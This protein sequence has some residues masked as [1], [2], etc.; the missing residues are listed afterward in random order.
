MVQTAIKM[1]GDVQILKQGR[2][3]WL[4]PVTRIPG[5]LPSG[6]LGIQPDL[7]I[8]K[9]GLLHHFGHQKLEI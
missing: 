6:M 1:R 4:F 8:I 2:G 3:S 7:L 9:P 5:S